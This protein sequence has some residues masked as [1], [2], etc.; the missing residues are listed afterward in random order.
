MR[1]WIFVSGSFGLN[2]FN[3]IQHKIDMTPHGVICHLWIVM[4]DVVENFRV[5]FN[6]QVDIGT[7][8]SQAGRGL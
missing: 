7:V 3:K 1:P 6:D 8:F 4:S 5:L 2:V